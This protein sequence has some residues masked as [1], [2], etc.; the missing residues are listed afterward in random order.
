MIKTNFVFVS[1]LISSLVS[2]TSGKA[3][4]PTKFIRV[5]MSHQDV[6]TSWGLPN[7]SSNHGEDLTHGANWYRYNGSIVVFHNDTLITCM[8]CQ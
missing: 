5:G 7:D 4:E 8:N 3:K 2:L 1:I 6:L